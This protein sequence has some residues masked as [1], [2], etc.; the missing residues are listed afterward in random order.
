MRLLERLNTPTA[1][2]VVT[3][4]AVAA[5]VFIYFA[6]YLPSTSS[7]TTN[8]PGVGAKSNLSDGFP[9]LERRGEIYS[10]PDV[11][12]APAGDPV[13]AGAGDIAVCGA[14]GDDATA[15]LIE[16]MP[17]ATVLTIGDNA[18]EDGTAY[19]FANCYD[20]SW[21]RFKARTHPAVGNHEYQTPGASGYYDYFGP[22]AGDPDKGY[23]SYDLGDWHVVSLNSMCNQVGLCGSGSPMVGWLKK[24]LAENP[25]RCTLA[26][27][28]HP[29]FS[30]G[31]EHGNNPYM[32]PVW[33]ALY[34][35]NAEVVLSAHEHVYERFAPQDPG[36]AADPERGIREFVVGTG[37][38]SLYAFLP[39]KPNSEVRNADTHG[40]IT[41]T[42]HPNGYDWQFVP[43]AGE[44]FTDSGSD[45][46][47]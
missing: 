45:R 20:T 18:Y 11:L 4:A 36:G 35:A 1:L 43:V 40:V 37:G 19:D 25:T 12:R 32:R 8:D 21:G 15:K 26:Y 22:A 28:H 14:N 34:A 24:D 27:F 9:E 30:S 13:L 7:V 33:D 44:S 6:F 47:H 41:L 42:L 17:N 5:N 38:A 29:L 31:A 10:T 16:D 3:F 39:P 2:L 46:C 23:Y